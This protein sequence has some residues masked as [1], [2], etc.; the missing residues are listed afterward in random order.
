MHSI[1]LSIFIENKFPLK[2]STYVKG[3]PF[4]VRVLVYWILFVSIN[5]CYSTKAD[6]CI[7]NLIYWPDRVYRFD[8]F[9]WRFNQI[10]QHLI[11]VSST[12]ECNDERDLNRSKTIY[13]CHVNWTLLVTED[14]V[15]SN[16]SNS[17]C[18]YVLVVRSKEKVKFYYKNKLNSK[19]NRIFFTH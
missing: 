1:K 9:C 14:G 7:Y 13:G 5:V 8:M 18:A 16:E 4:C 10:D 11:L 6:A 3:Y 15:H 12:F 2:S 19:R 17:I